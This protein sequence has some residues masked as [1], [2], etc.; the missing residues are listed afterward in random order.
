[1]I[2]YQGEYKSASRFSIPIGHCL[3]LV[4]E[5]HRKQVF[6]ITIAKRVI[7]K[8]YFSCTANIDMIFR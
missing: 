3:S 8:S 1:M 6:K 5:Q 7:R 2:I 4:N